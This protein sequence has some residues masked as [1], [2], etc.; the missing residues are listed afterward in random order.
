MSCYVF[1][2]RHAVWQK[3]GVLLHPNLMERASVW[4]KIVGS[5]DVAKD[6]SPRSFRLATGSCVAA[7]L[8]RKSH[9]WAKGLCV[10][11]RLPRKSLSWAK[12]MRVAAKLSR[13]SVS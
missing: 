1:T 9:S 2:A 12:G 13:K 3:V 4:Q 11:A 10:A 7:R 8:P 5:Q 6:R